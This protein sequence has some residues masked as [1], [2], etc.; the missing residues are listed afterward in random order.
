MRQEIL[1][2][3]IYSNLHIALCAAIYIVGAYRLVHIDINWSYIGIIF[4]GTVISYNL[5][6]WIG[7]YKASLDDRPNRFKFVIDHKAS[8]ITIIA[9]LSIVSLIC[10]YYLPISYWVVLVP[11]GFITLA[12][13]LPIFSSGKKRLRDLPFVKIFAIAFVWSALFVLPIRLSHTLIW[14]DQLVIFVEKFC[15]FLALTIPFDIRDK[16][17]DYQQKVKTFGTELSIKHNLILAWMLITISMGISIYLY[18]TG[19]YRLNTLMAVLLLYGLL[20][21]LC[22]LGVKLRSELFYLGVMDGM[23]L[24]VGTIYLLI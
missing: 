3:Y 8:L 15:F 22:K 20:G 5:H 10:V 1:K 11:L 18:T 7:Y 24:L 16:Q 4:S 9:L 2:Y 6:R 12:Y 19:I 14:I 23:I 21:Y 13:L 17:I